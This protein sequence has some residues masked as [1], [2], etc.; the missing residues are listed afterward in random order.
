LEL[1]INPLYPLILKG[2][3]RVKRFLLPVMLFA[4]LA[5][6]C[7]HSPDPTT[8]LAAP[9][10]ALPPRPVMAA[11]SAEQPIQPAPGLSVKA[12]NGNIDSQEELGDFKEDAREGDSAERADIAD[13]LE[14]F[15]RAMYH[16]NDKLYFWVLKPVAQGYGKVVP[17]GARVS[18][19]NFFSNLRFP[20]RFINSLLQADFSGAATEVGRFMVNTI[21]GIGGLLDPASGKD[22]NLTKQERDF[23]QTLGV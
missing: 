16:F 19:D 1:C 5:V 9:A 20:I 14:P 11:S 7:A 8:S 18:V 12:E 15:N 2:G 10:T 23:G 21:W 6:G 22:I 3:R 17:E 13:P 4:L